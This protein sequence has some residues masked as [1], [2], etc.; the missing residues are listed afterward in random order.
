[1]EGKTPIRARIM[2]VITWI[3]VSVCALIGIIA[4]ATAIYIAAQY[5]DADPILLKED[6]AATQQLTDMLDSI[7][8]GDFSTGSQYMLGNP[9]L[10]AEE[11]PED[12][13]A[14]LLWDTWK[15]SMSYELQGACYTSQ[16]GLAQ[17]VTIFYLD[18]GS[19]TG[20]LREDAEKLMAQ[21][22]AEAED[23][24]EIYDENNEYRQEF[25][26]EVLCEAAE[27]VIKEYSRSTSISITVHM[28]YQN[29]QWWVLAEE[30]LLHAI[31]GGILY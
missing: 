17:D 10:G 12:A 13:L 28:V 9:S 27:G 5:H 7:C 2:A 25:V 14:L 19:I 30:P 31:S 29:G 22:I 21:R 6:K 24:S 18:I 20:H 16:S 1:M 26:T 3:T 4:A 8:A 23:V 11:A 15:G